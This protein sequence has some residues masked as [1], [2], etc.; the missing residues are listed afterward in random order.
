[1][2]VGALVRFDLVL[3]S[4]SFAVSCILC[5]VVLLGLLCVAFNSVGVYVF[6]RYLDDFVLLFYC[7]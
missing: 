1:M 3:W 7:G 5:S 6:A 2:L 4:A